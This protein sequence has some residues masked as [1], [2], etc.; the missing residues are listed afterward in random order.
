MGDLVWNLRNFGK[1]GLKKWLRKRLNLLGGSYP[2][3][4]SEK[5]WKPCQTTS[6]TG[7]LNEPT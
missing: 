1:Y 7:N 6:N 4:K 3:L 5:L 2:S